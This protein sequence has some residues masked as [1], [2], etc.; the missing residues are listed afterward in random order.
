[1]TP[2]L[3]PLAALRL[4]LTQAP[5]SPRIDTELMAAS[6]R[7]LARD[8]AWHVEDRKW[9]T[10]W[11]RII[12]NLGLGGTSASS[13][14]VS[15][16]LDLPDRVNHR[17]TAYTAAPGQDKLLRQSHVIGQLAAGGTLIIG[18]EAATGVQNL[19]SLSSY[20]LSQITNMPIG[21]IGFGAAGIV[22]ANALRA[23]GFDNITIFERQPKSAGIWSRS[24]VHLGTRNNPRPLT[25]GGVRL[26]QAPGDG[27]HVLGVLREVSDPIS[28]RFI[29]TTVTRVIPSNLDHVVETSDGETYRFPILINACGLGQPKPFDDPTRMRGPDGHVSAVRW[30]D[31]Q[32]P[33]ENRKRYIFVGLGNST[34][35][36]IARVQAFIRNG[37]NLDYRILTHYP[38]DAVMNPL[39]TISARGREFRIFRDL[40]KPNLTSYQGDLQD[41][42]CAYYDAMMSGKIIANVARWTVKDKNGR[43]HLGVYH[44]GETE[45]VDEGEFDSLYVLTGYHHP[46]EV[47]TAF[48][49]STRQHADGSHLPLHDYDGE[50]AAPASADAAT[51]RLHKGY[52]AFGSLLSSPE[53]RN[54]I[55]IPGMLYRLPELIMGVLA[56]GIE[57]SV[58]F[59]A[60]TAQIVS[61]LKVAVNAG[62]ISD[63]FNV[64][65][66]LTP[67][68]RGDHT[69]L[70]DGNIPKRPRPLTGPKRD[71]YGRFTS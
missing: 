61:G 54:A 5:I 46:P 24:T 18:D 49:I 41:S 20:R 51:S 70:R 4:G 15:G 6:F 32:T 7:Q 19:S 64:V 35:E 60:L 13:P 55:V 48:G 44:Y 26:T 63:H 42:R 33:I 40:S 14:N 43:R 38:L 68:H 3:L 27:R 59:D 71:E 57:W 10:T 2:T 67:K 12:L 29:D 9:S 21:I 52:F 37:S 31:P 45:V 50:V 25:I 22:V 47:F 1:M 30:Q 36:M 69:R 8:K 11:D 58:A 28:A 65:V 53:N 56:R 34:A 16:W 17:L 39:D 66:D 23:I 62:G